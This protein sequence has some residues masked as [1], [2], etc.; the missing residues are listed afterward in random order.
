MRDFGSHPRQSEISTLVVVVLITVVVVIVVVVGRIGRCDSLHVFAQIVESIAFSCATVDRHLAVIPGCGCHTDIRGNQLL[1]II[2]FQTECGSPL[3][4][5]IPF[6]AHAFHLPIIFAFFVDSCATNSAYLAGCCG[7]HSLT[8]HKFPTHYN[9]TNWQAAGAKLPGSI[10]RLES[11]TN[12]AHSV[13][14]LST[15]SGP[16]NFKQISGFPPRAKI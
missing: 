15:S 10:I 5:S 7:A 2:P 8:E 11:S 16:I 12:S 6:G 13:C 4:P 3:I 9:V 14:I 1:C